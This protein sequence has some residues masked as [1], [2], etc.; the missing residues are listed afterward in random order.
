MAKRKILNRRSSR[1]SRYTGSG[2]LDPDTDV[3]D[4]EYPCWWKDLENNTMVRPSINYSMLNETSRHLDS[5]SRIETSKIVNE[6]WKGLDPSSSSIDS[7]N[8]IE[9]GASKFRVVT[10]ESEEEL[11]VKKRKLPLRSKAKTHQNNAFFNILNDFEDSS[12]KISIPD[13]RDEKNLTSSD[14]SNKMVINKEQ[15]TNTKDSRSNQSSNLNNIIKSK[16]KIFKKNY[17][18]QRRSVFVDAL[19]DKDFIASP[20][21]GAS[22]NGS[23][24]TDQ[25]N[26]S[27]MISPDN[28]SE[29][30]DFAS[31]LN[32][33]HDLSH[34]PAPKAQST[35]VEDSSSHNSTKSSTSDAEYEIVKPKPKLLRH[36]T[37]SIRKNVSE[38][39][40]VNEETDKRTKTGNLESIAESSEKPK[41]FKRRTRSTKRNVFEDIFAAEESDIQAETSKLTSAESAEIAKQSSI[42]SSNDLSK[43]FRKLQK[44][45]VNEDENNDTENVITPRSKKKRKPAI[46]SVE[47]IK[48][49][50]KD[51]LSEN[52]AT[53]NDNSDALLTQKGHNLRK[54]T[55]VDASARKERLTRQ[56]SSMKRKNAL[57]KS[58]QNQD[59]INDKNDEK[60]LNV[61]G[62][63]ESAS[64]GSND[65]EVSNELQNT[66]RKHDNI[67][68][69]R[70]VVD[71]TSS[72]NRKE[73]DSKMNHGRSSSKTSK[74]KSSLFTSVNTSKNKTKNVRDESLSD[75]SNEKTLNQLQYVDKKT[76][77]VHRKSVNV[78][79]RNRLSSRASNSTS[80]TRKIDSTDRNTLNVDD[81]TAKDVRNDDTSDSN[82][83]ELISKV[84]RLSY[85][86]SVA[87][88]SSSS[89]EIGYRNRISSRTRASTLA[90][91]QTIGD[92][93]TNSANVDDKNV[94]EVQDEVTSDSD[95]ELINRIQRLSKKS[96]ANVTLNVDGK[97]RDHTEN[98]SESSFTEKRSEKI[99]NTMEVGEKN[100]KNVEDKGLSDSSD[101]ELINRIQR[102]SQ[103]SAANVTLNADGKERDHTENRSESSFTEKRSEKITNTMEVS[104]KNL[105]NIDNGLSDSSDEE[106]VRNEPRLS[107]R[108]LSFNG[109]ECERTENRIRVSLGTSNLVPLVKLTRMNIMF[110]SVENKDERET[111]KKELIGIGQKAISDKL[112]YS[113]KEN[114][115]ISQSPAANASYNNSR[116][117]RGTGENRSRSLFRT[118]NL[119]SSAKSFE[120]TDANSLNVND[121]SEREVQDEES[122][123]NS[124]Q[125]SSKRS[126]TGVSSNFNRNG[127]SDIE[128]HHGRISSRAS[129]PASTE[130]VAD[131]NLNNPNM[132]G[133]NLME[134]E[135]EVANKSENVSK[136]QGN[137]SPKKSNVNVLSAFNRKTGNE[138]TSNVG[139][140][141]AR[142]AEDGISDDSAN[143]ET[144]NRL[145]RADNSRS[146]F[147]ELFE[148]F[149][150][151]ARKPKRQTSIRSFFNLDEPAKLTATEKKKTKKIQMELNKVKQQEMNCMN[152]NVQQQ[153]TQPSSTVRA[154]MNERRKLMPKLRKKPIVPEQVHKAYLVNGQVYKVPRL[155]R[156]KA[157]VTD[158]LYNY[159]WK[160]LEPKYKFETRV[161][162]EKFIRRVSTVTTS[163]AKQKSYRNY[164]GELYALM[165][166]MARLGIVR[167]RN[168]FYNFCH[169]FFPYELRA[170]MVPMLLPGNKR[171]IPYDPRMLYKPILGS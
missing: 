43:S 8:R 130:I 92:T 56:G 39:T 53:T 147:Q 159:L 128:N 127:R 6:W 144:S 10:S 86:K 126:A 99:T 77:S 52:I 22:I 23:Q 171:N 96:A 136:K 29:S 146:T 125:R 139:D 93:H 161:I 149:F 166:E 48:E 133:K 116:R 40:S 169:D 83:E 170:K 140:I 165:K 89:S 18:N 103:K 134:T 63:D 20:Q 119:I 35:T 95:E 16:P 30:S 58:I 122:I 118:S 73:H 148:S 157:W 66:N 62:V 69:R 108:K 34:L 110:P 36:P 113:D 47:N 37:K 12:K 142:E 59:S 5:S 153:R 163:I 7:E 121:K 129:N 106:L 114:K 164:E 38:S 107:Q 26:S 57:Q 60:T 42:F 112:Q 27:N 45:V 155:P 25:K 143:E 109:K 115:N 137:I 68:L 105:E 61:T 150:P 167:T 151:S 160:L 65:K 70:S 85:R 131:V 90:S 76:N 124:V 71:V 49:S 156:P 98:R 72:F 51:R 145:Q 13:T 152:A 158:R 101:E 81:K 11:Q 55:D 87:N 141:N 138:S 21:R 75:I 19:Q 111:K 67:S 80:F 82:N 41:L 97:E 3:I 74:S 44:N 32:G 64:E 84:P 54:L 132:D 168:D 78:S 94:R 123:V 2:I 50:I 33:V 154:N 135:D 91:F 46:L 79:S 28:Q 88:V 1:S 120:N 100:L 162:S 24:K 102:L 117:K 104:E 17:K 31:F 14:S 15:L 4:N 9:K